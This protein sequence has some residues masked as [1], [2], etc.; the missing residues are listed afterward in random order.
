MKKVL[1]LFFFLSCSIPFKAD[2]AFLDLKTFL[3]EIDGEMVPINFESLET[4]D[5]INLSTIDGVLFISQS[6]LILEGSELFISPAS[7]YDS[8]SMFLTDINTSAISFD[9]ITYSENYGDFS[10]YTFNDQ[11]IIVDSL[12]DHVFTD[13]G[14][15]FVGFISDDGPIKVVFIQD[16]NLKKATYD[17]IQVAAVPITS[18]AWLLSLG[19]IGLG[20]LRIRIK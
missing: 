10:I 12:I 4:G 16:L 20:A 3:S 11:G 7:S 8:M 9:F 17:N 6:D 1:I 18:S 2:A 19:V 5:N 15:N 13:A 14:A